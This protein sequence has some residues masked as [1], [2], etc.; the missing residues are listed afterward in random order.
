HKLIAETPAEGDADHVPVVVWSVPQIPDRPGF[1]LHGGE[2]P[3]PAMLNGIRVL[4]GAGATCI[5]IPCNT[6]HYWYDELARAAGVPVLHI[7]DAAC[8]MLEQRGIRGGAVGLMATNGTLAAGFYQQRLKSRGY[9]PLL[10]T[11]ADQR[12]LVLP[13]IAGVKRFRLDEAAELLQQAAARLQDAGA[14]AIVLGCTEIPVALGHAGAGTMM[15]D[16]T[17]ALAQACVRWWRMANP[18]PATNGART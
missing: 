4:R 16:A 5:A 6:A 3:L 12:E 10:N 1:I 15:L 17:L 14:R 7:A 2:S 8:D 13:G 9:R 18:A 11:E